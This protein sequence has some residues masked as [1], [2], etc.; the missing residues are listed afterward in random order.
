MMLHG[1][2]PV[3]YADFYRPFVTIW[4]P[5]KVALNQLLRAL[6]VQH[7]YWTRLTVNS[8]VGSLPDE[9]PTTARLLQ[10]PDDFANALRPYYGD[11]IAG[12]FGELLRSHLTIAA[13]LVKALKANQTEAAADAQKRWYANADAIAAFLGSI[14]PYWSRSEWRKMMHLHLQL[15][16]GEVTTRI[17]GNYAENVATSR[18]IEEQAMQ[19]ADVMTSGIVRQFPARFLR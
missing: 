10:N 1:Y 19:M 9:Q 15:L 16:T 3:R 11:A 4:T 17:A 2:L 7:I 12:R 13:E 8:I 5:S 18:Q 6:W 14:N